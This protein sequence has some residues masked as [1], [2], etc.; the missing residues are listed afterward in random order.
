MREK[1]K[2]S[3]YQENIEILKIFL[4][5]ANLIGHSVGGISTVDNKYLNFFK[6]Q[7]ATTT[8]FISLYFPLC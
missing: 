8:D 5:L 6:S 2:N 1:H 7:Q 4:I 3:V